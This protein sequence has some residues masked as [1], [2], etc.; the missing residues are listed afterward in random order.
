[1]WELR[2]GLLKFYPFRLFDVML[3]VLASVLIAGVF[4]S[5]RLTSV[6]VP[7]R[8]RWSLFGL[9]FLTGLVLNAGLGSINRMAPQQERDWLAACQ[10][11]RENTAEDALVYSPKDGWAFKWFAQRPEYVSRKDCPQDA[12]GI[13][14]W[15]ERLNGIRDWGE[16]YLLPGGGYSREDTHR[17]S[18]ET[19]I[20]Y[21]VSRRFGPFDAPVVFESETYRI[22]R[23]ARE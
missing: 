11:L 9:A 23:I 19:E 14:E 10:W 7:A 15:N 17:L 2:M 13:R 16:D 3:P 20:D 22:Y 4:S 1:M 8:W 18:G 5:R 21:I 12:A 6:L